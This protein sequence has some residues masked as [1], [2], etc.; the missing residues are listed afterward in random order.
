MQSLARRETAALDKGAR[1]V[2]EDELQW[3]IVLF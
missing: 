1:K 3:S 2:C